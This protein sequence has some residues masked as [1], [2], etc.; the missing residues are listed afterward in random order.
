MQAVFNFL[1]F[2]L[3]ELFKQSYGEFFMECILKKPFTDQRSLKLVKIYK[4]YKEEPLKYLFLSL[5]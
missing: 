2:V 4:N 3:L 5:C 1:A